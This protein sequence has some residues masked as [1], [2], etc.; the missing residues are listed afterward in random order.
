RSTRALQIMLDRTD[1]VG[2]VGTR[3]HDLVM[4]LSVLEQSETGIRAADVGNQS[5]CGHARVSL[6]SL[7][8]GRQQG[9]KHTRAPDQAG[10]LAFLN[11]ARAATAPRRRRRAPLFVEGWPVPAAP[12]PAQVHGHA[13][14]PAIW[15]HLRCAA[16]SGAH[17]GAHAGSG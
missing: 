11:N 17:P 1:D 15:L 6:W 9:A 3:Q 14:R 2:I 5:W 16:R 4:T 10:R 12:Q 13:D 8:S 7:R